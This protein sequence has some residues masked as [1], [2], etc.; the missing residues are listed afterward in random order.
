VKTTLSI[1]RALA[2]ALEAPLTIVR[3]RANGSHLWYKCAVERIFAVPV[4]RRL[5]AALPSLSLVAR[6]LV[7]A[8]LPWAAAGLGICR[9]VGPHQS[10]MR[11][12]V[13]AS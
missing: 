9:R 8:T 3:G 12:M 4:S 6:Q 2:F 1:H 5:P 10:P 11:A 13:F 7:G